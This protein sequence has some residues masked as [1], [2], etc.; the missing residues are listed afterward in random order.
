MNKD[1]EF[2]TQM[3]RETLSYLLTR[4]FQ[5]QGSITSRHSMDVTELEVDEFDDDIVHISGLLT[6]ETNQ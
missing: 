1:M 2:V 6:E 3:H 5:N 4:Y